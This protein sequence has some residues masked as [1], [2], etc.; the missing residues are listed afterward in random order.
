VLAVSDVILGQSKDEGKVGTVSREGTAAR[1]R[2]IGWAVGLALALAAWPA[3]CPAGE[4]LTAMSFNVR[5][6]TAADG[7][8]HWTARRGMVFELLRQQDADLVGLQ[9][10]LDFQIEEIMAALP[11][12]AVTGVGRDD[13]RAAGEHAAILF[14][15]DRLR[16]AEAGTF[17]FSDTPSSPGSRSWG[18]QIPRICSWAR[19]V[20]RGG[21]AFW[22]YN[23]HL[24]HESQPSRERSTALLAQR[25]AAR[26]F[27]DE[28]VLVTGD[29]NAGE[30]NPAFLQL[31]AAPGP[32]GSGTGTRLLDTFRALHRDAHEAGTFTGFVFGKTGGPKIDHVLAS[33]GTEVLNA[34]VV[35]FSRGR[36]YP[37]DHFPVTA[38][39]RLRAPERKTTRGYAR[40][41]PRIYRRRASVYYARVKEKR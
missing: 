36:R 14:K 16:V 5:Y 38:R 37:S 30:D 24:D 15:R 19:F 2:R 26:P 29:F 12:Y 33:P 27:P 8:D 21:G 41:R 31:L 11:H 17:W 6:G 20:D 7:K 22:A 39:V 35:R 4:P 28:P 10:A 32:S 18:N 40:R 25:I 13:G 23:I 34:A 9:E 1:H 3:P